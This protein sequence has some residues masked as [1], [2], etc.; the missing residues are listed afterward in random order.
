M[1]F[2]GVE[3]T[4]VALVWT[5]MFLSLHQDWQERVRAEIVEVCGDQDIQQCL[6]HKD[7]LPK[8]KRYVV[9]LVLIVISLLY[10][11]RFIE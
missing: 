1:Y 3:S 8:P 6:Q 10:D 9:L 11:G 2:A 7:T 4:A 5:L